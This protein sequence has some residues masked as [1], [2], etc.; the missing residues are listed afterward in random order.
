LAETEQIQ[1]SIKLRIDRIMSKSAASKKLMSHYSFFE[2]QAMITNT[3]HDESA[4]EPVHCIIK[5]KSV[6]EGG[7]RQRNLELELQ[8]GDDVLFILNPG[9][10][11]KVSHSSIWPISE[12]AFRQAGTPLEHHR[13]GGC[14]VLLYRG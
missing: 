9:P 11:R 7:K 6:D 5:M 4:G 14:E 12:E 10:H 1:K 2:Y 3:A 13:V 8:A